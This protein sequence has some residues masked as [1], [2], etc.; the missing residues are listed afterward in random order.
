MNEGSGG[1]GRMTPPVVTARAESSAR[2]VDIASRYWTWVSY[3]LGE[4]T[5]WAETVSGIAPDARMIAL[6]SAEAVVPGHACARCGGPLTLSSRAAFEWV[7]RHGRRGSESCVD[8]DTDARIELDRFNDPVRQARQ[9]ASREAAQARADT[10]ARCDAARRAWE[11]ARRDLLARKYADAAVPE[12][13]PEAGVR[14]ETVALALLRYAPDAGLIA[15][16]S[17]WPVPLSAAADEQ[18]DLIASTVHAGLP[19]IHATSSVHAFVWEPASFDKALLA[20]EGVYEDVQ[21]AELTGSYYTDRATHYSPHGPHPLSASTA[22]DAHLTKRLDPTGMTTARRQELITLVVE[23]IADEVLRYFAEQLTRRNLPPVPE[24]HRVRLRDAA[25]RGASV[26]PMADLVMLAWRAVQKGA[27]A[28]RT[29]PRAPKPNMT[30][31]AVNQLESDVQKATADPKHHVKPAS[32]HLELAPLTRTLLPAV[33][34]VDPYT[35]RVPDLVA[36]LPPP[37]VLPTQRDGDADDEEGKC[38]LDGDR[39]FTRLSTNMDAWDGEDFRE[40]LE[41]HVEMHA[42][43]VECDCGTSGHALLAGF[44]RDL[45]ALFDD[46]S[47]VGGKSAGLAVAAAARRLPIDDVVVVVEDCTMGVIPGASL[48]FGDVLHF[49]KPEPPPVEIPPWCGKCDGDSSPGN[50]GA[51]RR[52]AADGGFYKCPECHPYAHMWGGEPIER[53]PTRT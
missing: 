48:Y 47:P 52:S 18:A 9:E 49:A 43:A 51:R 45:L 16:L 19:A 3:G 24:N 14:E 41:R 20:A 11:S 36:S 40:L 27:V 50:I 5:R 26:R 12:A 25:R 39:A 15:P 2:E 17:T 13:I 32:W 34:D 22:L 23:V 21:P 29:H 44:G 35:V 46:L 7:Y 38:E 28:A 37:I 30:V 42:E 33:L 31:H 10:R 8:C 4:T 53:R 1:S 6:T